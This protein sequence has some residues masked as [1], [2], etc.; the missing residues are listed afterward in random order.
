MHTGEQA[1]GLVV[2]IMDHSVRASDSCKHVGCVIVRVSGVFVSALRWL[3]HYHTRII[4]VRSYDRSH[5][6][7]RSL[8]QNASAA[9]EPPPYP[10][11]KTKDIVTAVCFLGIGVTLVAA[12]GK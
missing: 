10:S 2:I 5:Q 6:L 8:A 11:E 9:M 1:S 12:G 3:Y 7:T 4:Q